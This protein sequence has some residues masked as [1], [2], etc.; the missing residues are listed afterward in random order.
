[1][2]VV[3]ERGAARWRS[4]FVGLCLVAAQVGSVL[5]GDLDGRVVGVID[6]DTVDVL[7]GKQ[8]LTRVRLAGIDAPEKAMPYGQKAKQ[9]LSA[10]V[11]QKIVHVVTGKNDRHGR[12]IGKVMLDGQD[13]NLQMIKVGLAWH[14]KQYSRE[15]EASDR[16]LYA[17]A[18]VEARLHRLGLWDVPAPVPPWEWRA[19]RR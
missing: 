5:A 11:Y 14:Y 10:L 17:D 7:D 15:Q 16:Q 9:H 3:L 4:V 6:G 12:V 13:I 18:E 1:M 2:K 19:A 8:T